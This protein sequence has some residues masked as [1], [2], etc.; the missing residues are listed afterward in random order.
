VI[1]RVFPG[2]GF[3]VFPGGGFQ[4]FPGDRF[5]ANGRGTPVLLGFCNSSAFL[6]PIL[7]T[8]WRAL[9]DGSVIPQAMAQR[10]LRE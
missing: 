3:Q 5:G 7:A 9:V 6:V 4:V 2:G 1:F 10:Y 8:K